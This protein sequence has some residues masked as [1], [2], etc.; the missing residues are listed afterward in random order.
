MT[1]PGSP[2]PPA[3]TPG[4][5]AE[6][7]GKAAAPGAATQVTRTNRENRVLMRAP[8][9]GAWA[10]V[11]ETPPVRIGASIWRS[12]TAGRPWGVPSQE[13]DTV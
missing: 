8:S 6:A 2:E 12:V 11:P 3:K 7:A 10:G 5:H 9:C 13:M 1:P 4:H